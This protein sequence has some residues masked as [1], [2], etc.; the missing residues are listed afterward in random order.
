MPQAGKEFSHRTTPKPLRPFGPVD[1]VC[2]ENSVRIDLVTESP[3]FGDDGPAVML[4]SVRR[5]RLAAVFG[6]TAISTRHATMRQTASSL[7][8]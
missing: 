5:Q 4:L 8:S 7:R 6:T 2:T 1:G 3:N